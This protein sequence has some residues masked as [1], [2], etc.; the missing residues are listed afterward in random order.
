[1]EIPELII[2]DFREELDK[3]HIQ[4]AI[5]K[6][7]ET[8]TDRQSTVLK[9]IFWEGLTT[10]ET[11]KRLNISRERIRQ[12]ELKA[13]RKLRAPKIVSLLTEYEIPEA[14]IYHE[15]YLKL[16]KDRLKKYE[17]S[18]IEYENKEKLRKK[19]FV[20]GYYST[21]R[22]SKN[23]FIDEQENLPENLPEN[24]E[25]IFPKP[26]ERKPSLN[27]PYGVQLHWNGEKFVLNTFIPYANIDRDRDPDTY[28]RWLNYL[29]EKQ[30]NSDKNNY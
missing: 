20:L 1:M 18:F 12:I 16:E 21:L 8:L 30:K 11:A 6:V 5:S 24:H 9:C 17:S 25:E 28:D 3:N 4:W 23:V 22:R 7:L 15:K 10:K 29:I 14:K 2:G 26:K 19:S 13:L 27:P